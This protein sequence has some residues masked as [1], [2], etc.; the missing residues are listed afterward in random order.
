MTISIFLCRSLRKLTS[1]QGNYLE[2]MSENVPKMA[3][4]DQKPPKLASEPP[5]VGSKPVQTDSN[6]LQKHCWLIPAP[7]WHQTDP[8]PRKSGCLQ[9]V[10]RPKMGP[11]WAKMGENGSINRKQ[12]FLNARV[13]LWPQFFF[14]P[15]CVRWRKVV[16]ISIFWPLCEKTLLACRETA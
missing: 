7:S 3:K 15:D 13:E 6:R 11:K 14:Q 1:L 10:P 12:R 4:I 9:G 8:P 16:T 5:P 2:K